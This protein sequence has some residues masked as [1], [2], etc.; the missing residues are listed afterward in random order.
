[1]RRIVAALLACIACGASAADFDV[2]ALMSMLAAA[3][4]GRATFLETKYLSLLDHPVETRGE[5]RFT[6]PAHFEKRTIG[7]DAETLIADRDTVTVER[8][9]QRRTLSLTQYPEIA[10]FVDSIRGTLAG[11]RALLEK[12]YTVAL[13]G[14]PERWTLSLKPRAGKL[15]RVVSRI[16]IAGSQAHVHRVEIQQP[17][18]DRSVMSITPATP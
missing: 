11:D 6:P 14:T 1:M 13:A 3:P 15:T 8:A 12:T 10:V 5:L 16:E 4:P 9:G 17:D 18:G 7:L 2:A